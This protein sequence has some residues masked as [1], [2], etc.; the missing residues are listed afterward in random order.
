MFVKDSI[1]LRILQFYCKTN[2]DVLV[3]NRVIP[4]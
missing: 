4:Q 3:I 1:A 2:E